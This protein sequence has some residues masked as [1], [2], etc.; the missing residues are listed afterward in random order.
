MPIDNHPAQDSAQD[1]QLIVPNLHRRYSGVTATNR[2][3][4]VLARRFADI[5]AG[6]PVQLFKSHREGIAD[7]DQRRDFIYIDDVVRV[8]QWLLASP[9]V[10]GVFNV[11]TGEARSFRELILAG[12]AAANQAPKVEYVDM[13]GPRGRRRPC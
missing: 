9:R 4:S 12:Y 7:G 8:I 11:G 13:P 10:N 1:L 3:M 2:M 6:R 5:K